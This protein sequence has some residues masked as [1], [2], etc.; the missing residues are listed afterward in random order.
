MHEHMHFGFDD[1][2][3]K[4]HDLNLCQIQELE[5]LQFLMAIDHMHSIFLF[6]KIILNNQIHACS[7][8]HNACDEFKLKCLM[9]KEHC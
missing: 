2:G 5:F 7:L 8:S 1:V 3:G 6:N 4:S 9:F